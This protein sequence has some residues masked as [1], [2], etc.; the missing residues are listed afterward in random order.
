MALRELP[1]DDESFDLVFV[2]A[3]LLLAAIM[4]TGVMFAVLVMAAR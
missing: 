2:V 4:S 3:M 1:A